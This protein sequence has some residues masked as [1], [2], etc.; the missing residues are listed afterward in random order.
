MRCGPGRG[1]AT[2]IGVS[3]GRD[4]L[5]RPAST[6]CTTSN[7][8]VLDPNAQW[9]SSIDCIT[10]YDALKV[11][12]IVNEIRGHDHRGHGHPG[13]PAIFGM[14]F[15][16]VSVGEKLTDGGHVDAVAMPRPILAKALDFVDASLGRFVAALE[17]EH[18]SDETLI[19][20][21]AKHDQSPIDVRKLHMK[22]G[23][24]NPKA[25]SRCRAWARSSA[26]G[27]GPA[28]P[29]PAEAQRIRATSSKP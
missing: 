24:A 4:P 19:V 11:R 26:K 14:N 20:L 17:E 12:A 28:G 15:Q 10:V 9:T 18:K 2:F 1:N 27:A 21:G 13:T 7:C 23:S 6:A 25:W 22:K 3:Y 8:A 29:A 5:T 16:S